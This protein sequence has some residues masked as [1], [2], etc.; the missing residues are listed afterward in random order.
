VA[1]RKKA[2]PDHYPHDCT[3]LPLRNED[4]WTNAGPPSS[5]LGVIQIN[6]WSNERG[7]ALKER[8]FDF[9]P[10]ETRRLAGQRSS[11][12]DHDGGYSNDDCCIHSSRHT[13]Q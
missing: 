8:P 2:A 9:F 13:E 7:A 5:P 11:N 10:I 4:D 3:A 1:K 12:S 6:G